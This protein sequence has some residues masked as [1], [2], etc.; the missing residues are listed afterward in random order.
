MKNGFFL[1]ILAQINSRETFGEMT[2]KE[3]NT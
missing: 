2:E 1:K 3:K